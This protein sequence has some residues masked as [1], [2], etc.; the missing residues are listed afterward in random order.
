VPCFCLC[1]FRCSCVLSVVL[2][3]TFSLHSLITIEPVPHCT[4]QTL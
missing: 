3:P 2:S 1:P 4:S